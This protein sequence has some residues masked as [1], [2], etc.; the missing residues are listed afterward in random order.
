MADFGQ[1]YNSVI[2]TEESGGGGASQSQKCPC[3]VLP[4]SNFKH[5]RIKKKI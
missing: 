4:P 5:P 2:H 3:T 1:L